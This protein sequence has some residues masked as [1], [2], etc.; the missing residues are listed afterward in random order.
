[1][2]IAFVVPEFV[3]EM[4]GGGL[5]TYINNISH[6]L[7]VRGHLVTIIVQSS[8]NESML[9][10]EN[11]FLERVNVCL[12][13]VDV[14]IPGSILR[15]YSKVLNERLVFIHEN[16]RH[17]DVVQYANWRALGF[18]RTEIPTVVRISSD[19]PYWRAANTLEFNVNEEYNCIKVV[20]YMEELALM[21]AD[22]VF[23]P[24]ILFSK[25]ISKRTGVD[26]PVIE[27]PFVSELILENA[28]MFERELI[29][30][31]YIL[32]YG[33]LSLI[34]GTK[35]I[36]ESIYGILHDNPDLYYAIAGTDVGWLDEQG[37]KVSAVNYI[38]NNAKEYADRVI[39]LGALNREEL[40][41]IIRNAECCIFPSRVDNLPNACIE[42][43]AMGKIVVGTQ[44]ASFEQLIHHIK[45]GFLVER[46]DAISLKNVVNTVMQLDEATKE[47]ICEEAKKRIEIIDID[48]IAKKTEK[49]YEMA[50]KRNALKRNE[51][52]YNLIESKLAKE[53]GLKE[54]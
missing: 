41:P 24:S 47:S 23:G 16:I 20:D 35:Q 21:N 14:N 18:Y 8:K 54:L 39:Y 28:E 4:K 15:E 6:V 52:Y 45:N 34:K 43:M 42:A 3:T 19:W 17:I 13:D 49:V 1:V 38:T 26:I 30:K 25:I 27:S 50:I 46:E 48:E 31:K 11:I 32:T 40:Y 53:T 33:S 37:N 9:Y 36:G 5:S 7:A 29:G 10:A 2:N 51:G 22:M 44:G 12:D